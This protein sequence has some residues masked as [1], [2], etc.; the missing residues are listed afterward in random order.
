MSL[1][2]IDNLWK[3][4]PLLAGDVVALGGVSLEIKA[5]D[6][7]SIMGQ[8]GSGKSTMLNLL[9]CL[10]KPS[11]G[12]YWLGD[13]DVATLTDEQLS[14]V[15]NERIGFV[16]Q[17]FNLIP[18]LTIEENVEVPLFYQGIAPAARRAKSME[19]LSLVG[20]GDRVGHKPNEL[21][22]GQRQRAAIARAL[23]N[24][25]LI[26]LADEPTGNL[27]SATTLE[28]LDL[29]DELNQNGCTIIMVTHEADVAERTRRVIVLRD[30]ELESDRTQ[31]PQGGKR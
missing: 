30:G 4:Y 31:A 3:I 15:R 19:M 27:D 6:Y 22:G 28:I 5:G 24:D 18:W 17:S 29:F 21:S 26:I 25:P 16:F 1:V 2:K 12:Q 20:L 14:V 23:V 10:D 9:G 13:A 7:V 8:S 11:R